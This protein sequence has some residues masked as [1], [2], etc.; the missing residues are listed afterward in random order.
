[1]DRES[2]PFFAVR[3]LFREMICDTL[4]SESGLQLKLSRAQGSDPGLIMC[5][6]RAP[7]AV[8]EQEADRLGYPLQFR[9]EVDPGPG[10][11]FRDGTDEVSGWVG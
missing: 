2:V 11:W 4:S 8:L 7:M 9:D 1:M 6:V 5:R 3:T 10:F